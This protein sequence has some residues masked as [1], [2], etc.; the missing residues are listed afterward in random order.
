MR[1]EDLNN[2][3]KKRPFRPFRLYLS[4]GKVYEVRHPDLVVPGRSSVFVG[5]PPQEQPTAPF[6]DSYEIVS[7]IHIVRLEPLDHSATSLGS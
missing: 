7:L 5:T 3:L 4:D 6:W 2:E 1:P